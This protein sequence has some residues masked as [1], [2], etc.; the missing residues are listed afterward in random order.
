ML[1]VKNTDFTSR[2]LYQI[3]LNDYYLQMEMVGGTYVLALS[4]VG[5]TREGLERLAQALGEIDKEIDARMNRLGMAASEREGTFLPRTECVYTSAQIAQMREAQP[6]MVQ[7]VKWEGSLGKVSME[8]AYLYPPGS[9]LVVPGERISQDVIN[10]LELYRKLAFDIEGLQQ[11][12]YIE[13]W[14]NG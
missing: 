10:R 6:D 2:D 3:L 12:G 1:T 7:S 11:E 13:V 14:K 4:S 8:Y 9:P 5:D